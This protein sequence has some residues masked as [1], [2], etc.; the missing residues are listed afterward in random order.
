VYEHFVS[1][2]ERPRGTYDFAEGVAIRSAT[3]N[4]TIHYNVKVLVVVVWTQ[5]GLDSHVILICRCVDA[6]VNI[7]R[8]VLGSNVAGYTISFS[9]DVPGSCSHAGVIRRIG[10]HTTVGS[11]IRSER[12]GCIFNLLPGEGDRSVLRIQHTVPIIQGCCDRM[13]G[14]CRGLNREVHDLRRGQ[15]NAVNYHRVR[16]RSTEPVEYIVLTCRER[17]VYEHFVATRERPRGSNGITIGVVI[18]SATANDTIHYNF[19]RLAVV[20]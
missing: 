8:P 14:V 16:S 20:V 9:C 3:A 6:D 18:R 4:D 2:R 13:I 19:K 11:D 15:R 10:S 7:A 17:E 1:S 12:N 5:T